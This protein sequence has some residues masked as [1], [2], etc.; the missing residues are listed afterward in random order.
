MPNYFMHEQQKN[1]K[2][3]FTQ[4]IYLFP[5]SLV[6]ISLLFMYVGIGLGGMASLILCNYVMPMAAIAIGLLAH[7]VNQSDKKHHFSTLIALPINLQKIF[8]A[9]IKLISL[10]CLAISFLL[11][12]IT[13]ILSPM[14]WWVNLI[15]WLTLSISLLWQIPFSLYLDARYGLA[16]LLVHLLGSSIGGLIFSLT[17]LFWFFPYSWPARLMISLYGILPNGLPVPV[18]SSKILN[19]PQI[20][21]LLSLA[22]G[23]F[24]LLSHFFSKRFKWW[25]TQ[26]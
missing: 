23:L 14:F 10:A 11:F 9:K 21:F 15:G 1:K 12:I 22:I 13:I 20:I 4:I 5:I 7:Q 3:R 17:P 18:G 26:Q 19:W 2:S 25:L 8:Y 6:L 24:V 16:S